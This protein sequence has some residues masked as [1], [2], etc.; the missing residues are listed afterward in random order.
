MK[1]GELAARIDHTILKPDATLAAVRKIVDE[2][3]RF[4][5]ASVCVNGKHVEWVAQA[6]AGTNVLTCAVVGFPLGASETGIKAAEAALALQAGAREID[7]VIDVGALKDGDDERVTLDI[8]TVVTVAAPHRVKVILETCL[9]TRDEKI[10]ACRAAVAAGAAFV[11]TSTGFS[12]HGATIEDVRLMREIVGTR[13]QVKASGGIRDLATALAMI[14]AGA[15]R[16]GLSATVAVL[17]SLP[18]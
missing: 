8:G 16:L 15:D 10:R 6:L 14:E 13:A 7:M 11:K 1:R 5:C 18:D 12:T 2:A 4:G 9:L 17:E 3:I